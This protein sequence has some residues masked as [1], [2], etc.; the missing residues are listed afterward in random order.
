[1]DKGDEGMAKDRLEN[2]CSFT[3]KLLIRLGINLS[4]VAYGQVSFKSMVA[5]TTKLWF[6]AVLQKI[7]L[8]SLFITPAPIAAR[9]IVPWLHRLRGVTIGKDCLIGVFVLIDGVYPERVI[10]GE[11]VIIASRCNLIVHHRDLSDY[12]GDED[13]INKKGYVVE[14]IIIEDNVLIG[15]DSVILP[16]V[17]IGKGSV[18][19][20]GSVVTKDVPP[21]T[22][23]AGVPAKIIKVYTSKQH[24]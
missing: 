23:V 12:A 18:V 3:Y 13:L 17:R 19:G 7:A 21:N 20:A 15:S 1:M 24:Q 11:H 2:S 6:G 16:G 9:I 10:I 14:S 4:P 22:F 5:K 8:N